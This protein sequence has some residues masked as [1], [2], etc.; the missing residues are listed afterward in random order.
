[1]LTDRES[2]I[3]SPAAKM[4]FVWPEHN[5]RLHWTGMS[6]R[7]EELLALFSLMVLT[8]LFLLLSHSTHWADSELWSISV[9]RDFGLTSQDFAS[10][11]KP[12]FSGILSL[13]YKFNLDDIGTVD[14]ARW[15]FFG[16]GLWIALSVFLIGRE[17]LPRRLDAV[18]GALLLVSCTFF[19]SQGFRV[20]SDILACACQLSG[21]WFYLRMV[22]SQRW[23]AWL[24]ALLCAHGAM[25]LATPKAIYLVLVN[26]TF[27]VMDLKT[28]KTGRR[29]RRPL[30]WGA[31]GL[32]LLLAIVVLLNAEQFLAAVQFF[33]N[34]FFTS[35]YQPGYL[36][37]EAF[38][39]YSRF[40]RE[41]CLLVVLGLWTIGHALA[42]WKTYSPRIR[43]TMAAALCAVVAL[44]LH[45]ERLPFFLLSLLPLPILAIT[46]A[47]LAIG[48]QRPW[49]R[50]ALLIFLM[51]NGCYS[52]IRFYTQNNNS[53]QRLAM[54]KMKSYVNE[55]P[56]TKFFDG[57][58]VLPRSTQ[59]LFNIE[60]T[61]IY[62]GTRLLNALQDEKFDVIFFAARFYFYL[63]EVFDFLGR[64][65]YILVGGGTFVKAELWH[66]ESHRGI[67]LD[68][69][70]GT[71]PRERRHIYVGDHFM[72][73]N[74]VA[75][76]EL[77][78]AEAPFDRVACSGFGPMEFPAGR[79]FGKIFD[80][81]TEF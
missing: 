15:L 31:L 7:F 11:Y 44:L 25:L 70:C 4:T 66:N 59:Y 27:M 9:A 71:I 54:V 34:G 64:N 60:P 8:A 1:M 39:Y 69:L 26:L 37:G 32:A 55:Y 79:D 61:H 46:Y 18:W 24:V 13:L 52:A 65:N 38:S 42:Q 78:E 43:A 47:T 28:A 76:P 30:M 3:K 74:F 36:S 58:A 41:N 48:Q 20:R 29:L 53:I 63:S 73:M 14:A 51:A 72:S 75:H 17:I 62:T 22:K 81:D 21:L 23:K 80:F 6:Q 19:L 10:H 35:A 77:L 56:G 68:Q 33:A 2:G 16:S 57:T 45:N 49:W 5:V 67:H 40:V 50:G 12:L